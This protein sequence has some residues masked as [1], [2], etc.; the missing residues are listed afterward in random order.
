MDSSTKLITYGIL[1]LV[2]F[3]GA[4]AMKP[5][6]VVSPGYRGV[7]VT[8][9]KVDDKSLTPGLYFFNPVITAIHEMNVQ[10]EKYEDKTATYTKDI[11]TATLTYTINYNLEPEAANT[12]YQNVGLDWRTTLVKPVIEG[13]L[14]GTIGKWDA[15]DLIA[16]RAKATDDITAA[17]ATE[18]AKRH[19]QLTNFQITNIDYNDEFEK[20]VE[21]KVTAVQR[22]AEA[23]N[24]TVQIREEANQTI[25]AAKAQA[26]A[27]QIKSQALSQNQNLVAYEAVQRWDGTLPTYMMGSTIPFINVGGP[28]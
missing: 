3:I 7:E 14:K 17:I 2:L 13:E 28:K 23:Q 11:Q 12:I 26:E 24:K 1:G 27:M 5:F 4:F 18:L 19:V 8:L 25:I 20:A 21:A 10:T 16:N 15:V 22:A 9:G 6:Q